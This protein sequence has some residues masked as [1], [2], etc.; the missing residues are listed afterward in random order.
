[1][2]TMVTHVGE[3]N[4]RSLNSIAIQALFL[5]GLE[6]SL[7]QP[8]HLTEGINNLLGSTQTQVTETASLM[9]SEK[10]LFSHSLVPSLG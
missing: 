10:W 1:M 8:D 4:P 7:L 2:M 6:K 5:M 9:P 3:G